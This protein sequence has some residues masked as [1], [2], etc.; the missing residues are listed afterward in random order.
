MEVN[1]SPGLEG[2]EMFTQVDVSGKIFDFIEKKVNAL[3]N[4]K[5][6]RKV[7]I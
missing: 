1:A 5:V 4:G 7:T 2:I 6:K 3:K